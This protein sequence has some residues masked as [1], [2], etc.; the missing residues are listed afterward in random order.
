MARIMGMLR[1]RWWRK[2]Q[3]TSQSGGEAHAGACQA[4]RAKR[5]R[6]PADA[7]PRPGYNAS[8]WMAMISD[9]EL[10]NPSSRAARKFRRRFRPPPTVFFGLVKQ[11]KSKNWLQV[12]AT[13]VAGRPSVPFEMKLLGG[14]RHLGRGLCFGDIAEVSGVSETTMR[15]F[16][17]DFFDII[18]THLYPAHV[19]IPDS[20][21]E[22]SRT[23]LV[24]TRMG[25]PGAIGS[26]D[27]VHLAWDKCPAAERTLHTG[28]ESYPTLAFNVTV[29]HDRRI[30][31][32]K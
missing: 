11:F 5:R 8:N 1:R 20:Q 28:K 9:P 27:G 31:H 29:R 30:L 12:A 25:L 21:E 3:D 22:I 18:A 7:G 32:S 6:K 4:P 10:G 26:M 16:A 14:L 24:Y 13:D 17:L 19:R 2:R 15:A 23:V